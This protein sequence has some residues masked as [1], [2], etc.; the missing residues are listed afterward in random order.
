MLM[1]LL[2]AF[3]FGGFLCIL[4]QLLVDLTKLTPARILTSMVVLGVILGGS[5]PFWWIPSAPGHR[6]RYWAL[7]ICLPRESGRRLPRMGP[8]V[9]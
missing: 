5:I 1:R 8:L 7:A 3:L 6:C 2:L 4:G 9:S